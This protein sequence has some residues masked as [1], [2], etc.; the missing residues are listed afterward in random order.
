MSK[1]IPDLTKAA[2]NNYEIKGKSWSK[3][4]S[5][6]LVKSVKWLLQIQGYFKTYNFTKKEYFE[7]SSNFVAFHKNKQ[8]HIDDEQTLKE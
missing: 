7:Y 1:L 8:R 2:E 4:H 6:N 5:A 3:V